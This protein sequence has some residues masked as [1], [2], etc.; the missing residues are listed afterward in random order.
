MMYSFNDSNDLFHT[1]LTLICP[2]A[3][4]MLY[5]NMS[6]YKYF[7]CDISIRQNTILSQL[8]CS[9][10]FSHK[11]AYFTLSSA[12]TSPLL[13]Y[14]FEVPRDGSNR[15]RSLKN[16]G[17]ICMPLVHMCRKHLAM[18]SSYYSRLLN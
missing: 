14:N 1:F 7:G 5:C 16:Y 6:I 2:S 15:Y 10:W 8:Y 18:K 4:Y 17:F 12:C 3:H 13:F 11:I 9:Q